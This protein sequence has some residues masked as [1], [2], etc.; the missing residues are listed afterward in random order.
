MELDYCGNKLIK[1]PSIEEVF[2]H[3]ELLT[4]DVESFLILS[5]KEHEYMQA[6]SR[7]GGYY[8]EYRN[9]SEDNHFSS[10]REDISFEEAK[11][12]FELYYD[13]DENYKK[14]VEFVAGMPLRRNGCL[15]L[16]VIGSVLI[17]TLLQLAKN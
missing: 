11:K 4:D 14:E 5:R 13:G 2:K 6:I 17:F 16:L 8:I 12:V 9:G 1:E 15:N 7:A 3:I 10:M